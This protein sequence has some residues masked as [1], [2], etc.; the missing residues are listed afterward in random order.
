LIVGVLAI[1]NLGPYAF[2][3]PRWVLIAGTGA[4]LLGA[5]VTWEDRVRDGRAVA[6]YVVSMR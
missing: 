2:V 1:A 5:G 4:L 3:I 6:R